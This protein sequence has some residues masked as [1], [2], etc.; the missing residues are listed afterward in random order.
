MVR[1]FLTYSLER[2]K[3]ICIV[4]MQEGQMKKTNLRVTEMD[5]DG[6][7]FSALLPGRKKNVHI[8]MTDVLTAA[9]ARGDSGELE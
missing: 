5:E 1:R 7:G 2:E 9:Y 4:L 8:H 3:K 6:Q